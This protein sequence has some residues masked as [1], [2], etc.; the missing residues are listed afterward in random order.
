LNLE[1]LMAGSRPLYF[2]C[3]GPP[4]PTAGRFVDVEDE[5]GANPAGG[6]GMEWS[7]RDGYWLLGPFQPRI[8]ELAAEFDKTLGAWGAPWSDPSRPARVLIAS[9]LGAHDLT[10]LP[11]RLVADADYV[12]AVGGVMKDRD[13]RFRDRVDLAGDQALNE[14]ALEGPVE[15]VRWPA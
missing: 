6:S 5:T 4:G 10:D 12:I 3:D 2:V 14:L 8:V 1:G 15:Y 13:A 11:L 7:Q 9:E